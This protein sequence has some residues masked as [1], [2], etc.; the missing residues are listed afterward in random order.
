M[1]KS[2]LQKGIAIGII[3]IL[4][5]MMIVP[6]TARIA[7]QSSL[8]SSDSEILYVGGSGPGNYTKIQEAID[9]AIDGDIVFVYNGTYIENLIVDKSIKLM[10][11]NKNSTIIDGDGTAQ[12]SVILIKNAN[13]VNVSGFNII[14]AGH[15]YGV[16]IDSKY[17]NISNNIIGPNH[18]TNAIMILEAHNII[19]DNTIINE[20]GIYTYSG[21]NLI[22]RN[23]I[24][25]EYDGITTL[26]CDNNNITYNTL[27]GSGI[28]VPI[29]DIT[30]NNNT[31]SHNNI[32]NCDEG[33]SVSGGRNYI[34][35]NT[36]ST[37]ISEFGVVIFLSPRTEFGENVISENTLTSNRVGIAIYKLQSRS[38]VTGNI[39]SNNEIGVIFR[40]S[41][42]TIT[43]NT[44][45]NNDIGIESYANIN[46]V[47][48][49][50]NILNNTVNA[51][52]RYQISEALLGN[53]I[54][55]A[56]YW[57]SPKQKPVPIWGRIGIP[58]FYFLPWF[59]QYDKNPASEPY[60]LGG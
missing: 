58:F 31:V 9:N 12:W 59:P 28:S 4:I 34:T 21:Y 20:N 29:I 33:I 10:G 14:N 36:V 44:I 2:S 51:R 26:G 35:H 46:T 27:S 57:G 30:G 8:I 3:F 11:E 16:E 50:N 49:E 41:G 53:G 56:N 1:L 17:N 48:S 13:S 54:W 23:T 43:R 25:I 32:S 6:S 19:Y 47:V 18:N 55:D 22:S 38:I 5:G 7:E 39:I 60:D 37:N 24:I 40:A 52:Y 45:S 15:G 42:A